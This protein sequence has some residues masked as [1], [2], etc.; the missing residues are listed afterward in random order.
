MNTVQPIR[1][2][3]PVFTAL[4]FA[5][6]VLPAQAV[7][8][9][10]ATAIPHVQARAEGSVPFVEQFGTTL[11]W[12]TS[13][14][15]AGNGS[16]TLDAALGS[17]AIDSAVVTNWDSVGARTVVDWDYFTIHGITGTATIAA[18]FHISGNVH[19]YDKTKFARLDTALDFE[20]EYSSG[21]QRNQWTVCDGC[22]QDSGLLPVD[23]DATQTFQVSDAAPYFRLRYWLNGDA[24]HSGSYVNAVGQISFDLPEEG[25]WV[26][27]KAG[28]MSPVPEPEAYALMLAGLGLVGLT[29]KHSR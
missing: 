15:P 13:S 12:A 21:A 9:D 4:L 23:F 6:P 27:S 14:S 28:F 3:R 16:A 22:N 20:S 26:T 1:L 10:P 24:T 18:H 11:A 17:M 8:Y 7:T 25:A 5:V 29:T 2:A 19:A